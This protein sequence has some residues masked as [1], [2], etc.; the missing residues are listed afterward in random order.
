MPLSKRWPRPFLHTKTASILCVGLAALIGLLSAHAVWRTDYLPFTHDGLHHIFR[1]YALDQE[2]RSGN[3]YPLRFPSLSIGYG[4]AILSYYPPLALYFWEALRLAGLGYILTYQVGYT[5]LAAVAGISSFWLGTVVRD[6]RM[7][8]ITAFVYTF[9]PYLLFDLYAR[10]ALSEYAALAIAPLLFVALHKAMI[11]DRPLHWLLVSGAVALILLAHFLSMLLFLPF[12]ALYTLAL[13]FCGYGRRPA[14]L[15]RLLASGLLGAALTAFYWLP[16]YVERGGIRTPNVQDSLAS[17]LDGILPIAQLFSTRFQLFLGYYSTDSVPLVNLTL[18]IG[19]LGALGV[20]AWQLA[21]G[22]RRSRLLFGGLLTGLVL[23]LLL[24]TLPSTRLWQVLSPFTILQFPFRWLGPASLCLALLIGGAGSILMS[25]PRSRWVGG[26]L[27]L[28]LVAGQG[29]SIFLSLQT[30]ESAM[31]RS[32]GVSQIRD[33]NINQQGLLAYEYDEVKLLYRSNWSWA[34]EYIPGT[35][36]LH[37]LPVIASLVL[38]LQP[39]PSDLPPVAAQVTTLAASAN[40]VHV[41]VDHDRPWPLSLHAFYIPGWHASVDDSAGRSE[42]DLRRRS[43]RYRSA[44]RP[45][46]CEDLVWVDAA[47]LAGHGGF[48]GRALALVARRLAPTA[49]LGCYSAL[50]CDRFWRPR[51]LAS[52]RNARTGSHPAH[53]G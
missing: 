51:S 4:S 13:I 3:W 23:A 43:G 39:L 7:G 5:L 19:L 45:A 32:L 41:T 12:L 28:L 48:A 38:D 35:S 8:L 53:T 6:R 15:L 44:G 21:K 11:E 27:V 30:R 22:D 1:L 42:T 26:L 24:I 50:R 49:R 17:Y 14:T 34:F 10:S 9:S 18:L 25:A 20:A 33:E 47:A 37:R 52:G 36:S 31:L 46:R 40:R 16:A 29:T 2:I